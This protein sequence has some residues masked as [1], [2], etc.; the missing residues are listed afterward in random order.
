MGKVKIRII[1]TD[2]SKYDP[3]SLQLLPTK[4]TID[5]EV[6][7]WGL[8]PEEVYREIKDDFNLANQKVIKR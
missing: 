4:K 1:E 7:A 6:S 3:N 2:T 5:I 8:K